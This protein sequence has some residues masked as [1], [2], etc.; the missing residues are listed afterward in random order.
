MACCV[1]LARSCLLSRLPSWC[2]GSLACQAVMTL[3]VAATRRCMR[4]TIASLRPADAPPLP[5]P[6]PLAL[7]AEAA[8][9]RLL[10]RRGGLGVPGGCGL[11]RGRPLTH[12]RGQRPRC[13]VTTLCRPSTRH[14]AQPGNMRRAVCWA[15]YHATVPVPA[16]AE[17]RSGTRQWQLVRCA[18]LP[19][20]NSSPRFSSGP[21]DLLLWTTPIQLFACA[22]RLPLRPCTPFCL[23]PP[24]LSGPLVSFPA[25]RMACLVGWIGNMHADS[26]GCWARQGQ[27]CGLRPGAGWLAW[28]AGQQQG[29]QWRS[30]AR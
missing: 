21:I 23:L 28:A 16:A 9:Q 19:A 3:P 24:L 15:C 25:R 12:Q 2:C 1:W 11:W 30:K 13:G 6:T 22:H 8:D 20:P 5:P 10:V 14:E 7:A 17:L 18:S 29:R 4:Q 27:A 26:K